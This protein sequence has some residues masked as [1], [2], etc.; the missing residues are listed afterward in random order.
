MKDKEPKTQTAE[1]K[2]EQL[3]DISGGIQA[4]LVTGGG[5]GE[6]GPK[7][8]EKPKPRTPYL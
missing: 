1:V 6:W 3:E 2:D 8:P 7:P 5:S 4:G